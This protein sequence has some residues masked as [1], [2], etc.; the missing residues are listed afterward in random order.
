MLVEYPLDGM[1]N[2][3]HGFSRQVVTDICHLLAEDLNITA[4]CP[5]ALLVAVKVT[6]ALYFYASGSFQHLLSAIEGILQSTV[7]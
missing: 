7:S 4:S 2:F 3:V 6:A 1:H 5:D